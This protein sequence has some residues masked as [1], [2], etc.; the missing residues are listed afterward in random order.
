[1]SDSLALSTLIMLGDH[2]FYPV[3][4]LNHSQRE[5]SSDSL[6]LLLSALVIIK[7]FSVSIYLPILDI[8]Q[9]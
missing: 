8:S 3:P 7:L 4:N 2:H 5:P 1:M 6:F 9:K